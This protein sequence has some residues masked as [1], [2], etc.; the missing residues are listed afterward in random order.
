MAYCSGELVGALLRSGAHSYCEF[1]AV[2]ALAVHARGQLL[3]Q[4]GSRAEVFTSRNL[5]AA[6]KR[7]LM[8]CLT[9]VAGA[10][11]VHPRGLEGVPAAPRPL[12]PPFAEGSASFEAALAAAGLSAEAR[13]AVL[14]ALALC[15]ADVTCA[16]GVA[17]LQRCASFLLLESFTFTVVSCALTLPIDNPCSYMASLGRYGAPGAFLVPLYGSPE[18]AQAFCRSAAVA[19]ALYVLRRDVAAL[20]LAPYDTREGRARAAVTGVRTRA[21]QTLRC[22][23]LAAGGAYLEALRPARAVR[24]TTTVRRCVAVMDAPLPLAGAAASASAEQAGP[25]PPHQLLALLPPGCLAATSPARPV[26]ALQFGPAACVTPEDRW[27]LHLSTTTASNDDDEDA[28]AVLAP[29]LRAL[30]DCGPAGGAENEAAPGGTR[31]K[32][33]SAVFFSAVNDDD[34]DDSDDDD[35]WL[36]ANA[37]RCAGPG[38]AADVDAAVRAA[39]KAF[40]RLYPD[41]PFF[42]QPPEAPD[43]PDAAAAAASDDDEADAALLAQASALCEVDKV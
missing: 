34:D 42:A 26:R 1:K 33:R 24:R 14:H 18:L 8:R 10:A 16:T 39:E 30:V 35:A 6:D 28:E 12:P 22:A 32:L 41:L 13:A 36:P 40:A 19:G 11:A 17:A 20:L 15:D 5:A 37:A 4:P 21:G 43:V 38:A 9:A 31:P 29:A 27:L 2:E 3:R 23:A 7:A 25:Q